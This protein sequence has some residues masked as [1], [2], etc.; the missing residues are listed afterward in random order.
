MPRSI[1]DVYMTTSLLPSLAENYPDYAIYFAT[2]PVN[3]PVLAGNP[4]IYKCIPYHPQ[5]DDLLFLEGKGTHKGF[6]DI[7]FLP[8]IG[9]QKIFNYQHNASDKIQFDICT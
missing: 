2:N 1:G 5:M 3:F 6:F 7:A 4:Y 8:N 9:T